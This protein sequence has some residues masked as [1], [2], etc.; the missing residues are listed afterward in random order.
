MV[1]RA[2][3][4]VLRQIDRLFD[5]GAIGDC[6]DGQLLERFATGSAQ[7]AETAFATLVERHGPLVM[8]TCQAILRDEHLTEDAFQATFMVLLRKAR[9]LWVRDSLGP[10]L[11]QV[12]CR[13]ALCA[14]SATARRIDHERRYAAAVAPRTLSDGAS[15]GDDWPAVLHQELHRLPWSLRAPLVLCDLEC[16]THEQAARQL[17]WPTGTLKTRL[18]RGR[19]VLR[20]RLARCGVG[21]TLAQATA[22]SLANPKTAAVPPALTRTTVTSLT[23]LAGRPIGGLV[24][25]ARVGVLGQGVLRGMLFANLRT[26]VIAA[27]VVGLSLFGAYSLLGPAR[28][29]RNETSVRHNSPATAPAYAQSAP[30]D[31]LRRTL[32]EALLAAQAISDPSARRSALVRIGN[33]LVE[34]G[35]RHGAQATLALAHASAEMIGSQMEREFGLWRV[36]RRQA[37]IG[38]VVAARRTFDELGRIA[39]SR[40]RSARVELFAYIAQAQAQAGLR[41]DALATI[42]QAL[43]VIPGIE[44]ENLRNHG[45]LQVLQAQ[46]LAGDFDGALASTAGLTGKQSSHRASFLQ[47]IAGNCDSAGGDQARVILRRALEL[48]KG[49]I[50]PYPRAMAQSSIAQALARN[51]DIAAALKTAHAIGEPTPEEENPGLLG[52]LFGARDRARRRA[53]EQILS[54][55][56]RTEVAPALIAIAREQA[57]GPDRAGSKGTFREAF[58]LIVQSR[59]GAGKTQN[60]RVLVE[61]LAASGEIEAAK[62]AIG[63]FGDDRAS[64]AR[65]LVALA[66]A[67]AKAGDRPAARD[68]LREALADAVAVRHLPD[69]IND[70]PTRRKDEAMQEIAVAQSEIGEIDDALATVAS[71]GTDQWK[72]GIL[73]QIAPAQARSGDIRAALKTAEKIRDLAQQAEAYSGIARVQAE[74][75]RE[76]DARS[77]A[78]QLTSPEAR[79]LALVGLVEGTLSAR[80]AP[81]K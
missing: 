4:A 59:D 33:A 5:V 64:K 27:S 75:G 62:E 48:S 42:K 76:P 66:R 34:L 67:Q 26:L 10:W 54:D 50:Y 60:M 49:V 53:E 2:D 65:A 81:P 15:V 38:D 32:D 72:A 46:M 24:A 18:A 73:A 19:S 16:R 21:L 12:A 43:L 77:W 41:D 52:N 17:G 79:A 57:R 7:S 36:A 45:L 47:Y 8:R 80:K 31:T 78:V 39:E 25:S 13:T 70:D 30:A 74:A 56:A 6:T 37:Q 61:A 23:R 22:L 28:A 11:H 20:G 9:S 55:A 68:R 51:G 1:S 14:R 71:Y 63:A 69:V 35:D 44:Q 3:G 40:G 58:G 29:A